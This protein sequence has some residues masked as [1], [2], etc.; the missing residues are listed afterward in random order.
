MSYP[1][2]PLDAVDQ[3]RSYLLAL[4]THICSE[5]ESIDGK[6]CFIKDTWSRP[7][8]GGGI[9]RVLER[10]AVF[11]KAGV[12]F[13][14]VYGEA[15][16][17]SATANRPELAGC[18][19]H[20]LGVSLVIHPDNPY[21]PTSHANVRFFVAKRDNLPVAWWFGGGFDL[22]PYY[23]FDEDC[24][25]WHTT[26]KQACDPFG[27]TVYPKFKAWCDD[28]FYLKHR[29]EARGIGGLFFDDYCDES[30]EKSFALMQSIGNSYLKAYAP[31]VKKRKDIPF[32]E[33]EKSFQRYR[34]GRYVEFNLIYD[35]GTLFGLQSN[36]RTEAILVSL[37]PEVTWTYLWCPDKNTPEAML[38]AKYLPIQNWLE[39]SLV[40]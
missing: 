12:N 19:F 17:A 29:N 10:G 8:G 16:P 36:G 40:T 13:S 35:R 6:A 24:I 27:E 15:L 22:T 25:H 18:D 34:R 21:V 37:P 28:Y 20:A 2:L 9:S 3:I 26:A 11:E 5:F 39:A 14:E 23:G 38:Y 33:R 32:G 31:I 4:Q 1:T 7:E 30:F